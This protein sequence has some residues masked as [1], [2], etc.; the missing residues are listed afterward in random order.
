MVF[1]FLLSNGSNYAVALVTIAICLLIL[2]RGTTRGEHLGRSDGLLLCK[3]TKLS[4][5]WSKMQKSIF[6]FISC[7]SVKI[8]VLFYIR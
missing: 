8:N 1:L 2:A 7:E 3:R 4:S 6:F 5:G